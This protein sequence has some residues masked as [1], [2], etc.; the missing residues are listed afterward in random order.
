MRLLLV[1]GLVFGNIYGI[2]LAKATAK[3]L[4][5]G[6]TSSF[7]P[8]KVI[9]KFVIEWTLLYWINWPGISC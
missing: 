5:Q 6:F 2:K 4:D 9:F 3:D 8:P 7:P 1:E